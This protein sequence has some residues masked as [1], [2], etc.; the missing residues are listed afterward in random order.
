MAHFIWSWTRLNKDS[1]PENA[2]QNHW[3]NSWLLVEIC[4]FIFSSFCP[5][6]TDCSG[7]Y[8]TLFFMILGF[9]KYQHAPWKRSK[10]PFTKQLRPCR[11][12][13]ISIF[14]FCPVAH[15]LLRTLP[16]PSF[17]DLRLIWIPKYS[18]EMLQKTVY[19]RV[20]LLQ[21]WVYSYVCLFALFLTNCSE[22]YHGSFYM[23]LAF[24]WMP[25]HSRKTLQKTICKAVK[26]LSRCV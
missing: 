16:W 9:F 7:P 10:R 4:L 12:M 13:P 25:T 15:Q 18:K 3:W 1:H 22:P 24:F 11:Y 23:I 21:R 2:P 5:F 20:D 14:V 8:H 19:E 17:H 6:H 26:S